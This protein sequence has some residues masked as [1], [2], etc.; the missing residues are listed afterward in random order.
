MRNSNEN[1][2]RYKG[3]FALSEHTEQVKVVD[4][5]TRQHK[6]YYECLWSIPN[7]AQLAGNPKQRAKQMNYLKAEGFKPGVSDLFLMVSRQ[8]YHGLFIEMKDKGKTKC[9]VKPNQWEHIHA[10]REQGYYATWCAGADKAIDIIDHYM[11]EK[12]DELDYEY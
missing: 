8:G 3:D 2:R 5:F 10:A 12:L 4:W 1:K 6:K 7:G 9:S 11:K